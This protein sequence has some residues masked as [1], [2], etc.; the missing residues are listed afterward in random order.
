MPWLSHS[1]FTK[2]NA[3]CFTSS[4]WFYAIVFVSS[5]HSSRK[6]AYLY[7]S[8]IINNVFT[9]FL[10]LLCSFC[11][12]F[13][14]FCLP[15]GVIAVGGVLLLCALCYHGYIV[16]KSTVVRKLLLYKQTQP[17]D[18]IRTFYAGLLYCMHR[19]MWW[20]GSKQE[21]AAAS[22]TSGFNGVCFETATFYSACD[23]IRMV[24]SIVCHVSMCSRLSIAEC[25]HSPHNATD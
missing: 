15:L 10:I 7:I 24:V 21:S 14:I 19:W 25:N 6:D 4:C 1:A 9:S 20:T 12:Y 17:C 23:G 8:Q 18:S 16:Q 3:D 11:L 5:I 22:R 13:C 2:R